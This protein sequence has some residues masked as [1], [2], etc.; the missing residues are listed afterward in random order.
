MIGFLPVCV[1]SPEEENETPFSRKKVA[2]V[3]KGKLVQAPALMHP[4]SLP[5]G[6]DGLFQLPNVWFEHD[7]LCSQ[8]S[9]SLS[10]PELKVIQ[11]LG[12]TC[13]S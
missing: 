10:N 9:F 1:M 6:D 11:G 13:R 4:R 7:K 12:V 3:D 2:Q 5:P 8:S